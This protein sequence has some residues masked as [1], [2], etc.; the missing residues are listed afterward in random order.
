MKHT[1]RQT[2]KSSDRRTQAN[3][4]RAP[5]HGQTHAAHGFVVY[6]DSLARSLV[7]AC[8]APASALACLRAC[9]LCSRCCCCRPTGW[10]CVT[11]QSPNKANGGKHEWL[12]LQRARARARVPLGRVCCSPILPPP[13]GSRRPEQQNIISNSGNNINNNNETVIILVV[14]V[15]VRGAL[16]GRA[17]GRDVAAG[18][19]GSLLFS[20]RTR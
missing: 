7:A 13:T 12:A 15:L 11:R 19:P 9:L 3:E 1:C 5:T 20:K 17:K 6:N 16:D 8:L 2:G 14:V 18:A 10:L 4:R